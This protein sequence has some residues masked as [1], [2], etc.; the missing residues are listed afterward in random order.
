[1]HAAYRGILAAGYSFLAWLEAGDG[2]DTQTW[3]GDNGVTLIQ[4]GITGEVR[5]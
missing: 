3:Y 4:S 2:T 5:A 1:M